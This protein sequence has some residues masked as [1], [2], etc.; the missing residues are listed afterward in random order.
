VK[1]IRKETNPKH[2]DLPK[3]GHFTLYQNLSAWNLLVSTTG[4]SGLHFPATR[5]GAGTGAAAAVVAESAFPE[6]A[7]DLEE[8][9]RLCLDSLLDSLLDS[10]LWWLDFED[11][12]T[13]L[14]FSD[15]S[16]FSTFASVLVSCVAVVEVEVALED[17]LETEVVE[18]AR[19]GRESEM[20]VEGSG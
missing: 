19:T 10:D 15:F 13:S 16:D 14:D 18:G 2:S 6:G 11:F 4:T 20:T 7:L 3:Q 17:F 9:S 8:E 1:R 12:L 5:A